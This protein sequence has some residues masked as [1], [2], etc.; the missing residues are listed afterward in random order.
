MGRGRKPLK[1]RNPV[2]GSIRSLFVSNVPG[3]GIVKGFNGSKPCAM[4]VTAL[5]RQV[6]AEFFAVALFRRDHRTVHH[7]LGPLWRSLHPL[8]QLPGMLTPVGVLLRM[9]KQIAS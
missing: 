8:N 1:I 3:P 6:A 2:I 4:T 5:V 9:Q 7:V